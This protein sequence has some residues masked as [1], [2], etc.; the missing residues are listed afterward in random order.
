MD[1]SVSTGLA[2]RPPPDFKDQ[3]KTRDRFPWNPGSL[4][5]SLSLSFSKQRGET[6]GRE[7]KN[8]QWE[9]GVSTGQFLHLRPGPLFF[10]R[11][12]NSSSSPSSS[13]SSSAIPKAFPKETRGRRKGGPTFLY[14]ILFYF[15][16]SLFLS[17][18]LLPF[19]LSLSLL[20]VNG[21]DSR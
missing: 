20:T 12:S 7:R 9:E 2:S 8:G 17:S 16:F 13:S 1:G 5:D 15:I 3:A 21:G 14:F 19:S 11:Y 18:P 4:L 6:R 10:E